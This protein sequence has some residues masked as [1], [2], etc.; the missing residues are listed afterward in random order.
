MITV[1]MQIESAPVLGT[2][3]HVAKILN[4]KHIHPFRKH[5]RIS[6]LYRTADEMKKWKVELDQKL[7]CFS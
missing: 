3:G 5:L 7:V 4:N 6:R 1:N 2:D